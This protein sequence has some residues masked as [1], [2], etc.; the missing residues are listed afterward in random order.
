MAK[1]PVTDGGSAASLACS[2][3]VSEMTVLVEAGF[4]SLLLHNM[5]LKCF[6]RKP[7]CHPAEQTALVPLSPTHPSV[8]A[9]SQSQSQQHPGRV[10]GAGQHD[11]SGLQVPRSESD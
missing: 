3:P 6:R 7:S 9:Q 5:S 11:K 1:V 4:Y 8:S 10:R 2:T